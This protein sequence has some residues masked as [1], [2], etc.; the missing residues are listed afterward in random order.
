MFG[1]EKKLQRW[2]TAGIITADQ[3]ANIFQHE[4]DRKSGRFG[5][6]LIGVALFSISIG[7][8]SMVAANWYNISGEVKLSVHLFFNML[9][10]V[11]IFQKKGIYREGAVLLLFGLTMTLIVL[12]GQVYQLGGSWSG[13]LTLWMCAVTPLVFIYGERGLTGWPWMLGFLFSS[14]FIFEGLNGL[15]SGD[16]LMWGFAV[17]FGV[18][19][20]GS[21]TLFQDWRPVYADIFIKTGCT[22]M[23][24]GASL[25]S[26]QWYMPH[27]FGGLSSSYAYL[28]IIVV[29]AQAL[30]AT[31][32]GFYKDQP[33]RKI[34]AIYVFGCSMSI[35]LPF[36]FPWL[37]S[38][39][40]GVISSL[41]FIV[42]WLFSGI[43]GQMLGWQ[44]LV[45]LAII[46]MTIR[47]F[48]GYVELFGDLFSTGTGL[49][50]GG[51]V[52]L[53]MIWSA[54]K[55]HQYLKGV[56]VNV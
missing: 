52:M 15:I 24:S 46:M 7:V 48:I 14:F 10:A 47:I 29:I 2:E 26:L 27:W 41:H 53:S 56:S 3:S 38:L 11:L 8:L 21:L 37:G 50:I 9:L 32:Y 49:I 6:G 19:A 40:D 34:L 30:Y 22:L 45:T 39:G 25:M 51:V 12:I 17:S 18:L 44:R 13:A 43:I 23:V 1:F 35:L 55:I 54:K 31:I 5:R 33:E 20:V 4:K 36:V 16:F 28:F 42:F